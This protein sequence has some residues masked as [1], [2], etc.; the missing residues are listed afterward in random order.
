MTV[1]F[2]LV[3]SSKVQPLNM[4]AKFRDPK[5]GLPM[6]RDSAFLLRKARG[7]KAGYRTSLSLREPLA[8]SLHNGTQPFLLTSFNSCE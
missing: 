8:A 4:K 6:C 7:Y 1:A 3:E 2:A 5:K